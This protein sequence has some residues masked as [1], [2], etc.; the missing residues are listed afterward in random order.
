[1]A[2]IFYLIKRVTRLIIKPFKEKIQVKSLIK[3]FVLLVKQF[4]HYNISSLPRSIHMELTSKCNLACKACYRT[5]VL[6]EYMNLNTTM[7]LSDLKK[8]IGKYDPKKVKSI[9]LSGGE[10]LLHPDFFEALDILRD[11]F[12]KSLLLL[13][14]NGVILSNDKNKLEKVCKSSINSIQVSLHGATQETIDLLQKGINLQKVLEIIEFITKNSKINVSVNYVIQEENVNEIS[15]F[16]DIVSEFNVK[17]V[18]L[19][20]MNYAGHREDAVNYIDLWEKMNL[21]KILSNAYKKAKFLGINIWPFSTMCTSVFDVDVL[22]ASGDVLPCWGQY[23]VK[24]YKIGNVFQQK[25]D[26]IRKSKEIK[27]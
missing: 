24:K 3:E 6:K 11:K 16:L 21:E 23:L 15:K 26:E 18:S 9:V 14:T 17:D 19:H 20:P 2:Q 12:T 25:P 13:A 7:T 10:N 27:E 5:G 22:T 4:L 1:M 8:L